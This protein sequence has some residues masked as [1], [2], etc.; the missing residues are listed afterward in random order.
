M[1]AIAACWDYQLKTHESAQCWKQGL[2][3]EEGD[4]HIVDD[5]DLDAECNPDL[6]L[7]SDLHIR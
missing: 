6:N 7:V 5:D 3:V 2:T 4:S 1:A